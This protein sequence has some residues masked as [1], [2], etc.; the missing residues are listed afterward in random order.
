MRKPLVFDPEPMQRMVVVR[1][2]KRRRSRKINKAEQVAA[3]V[4]FVL[5]GLVVILLLVAVSGQHFAQ[6]LLE[7]LKEI[8]RPIKGVIHAPKLEIVALVI[9]ALILVYMMPGVESTVKRWLG[10]NSRT[11]PKTR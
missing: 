9:A 7:H 8:V 3:R 11:K 10:I 5:L 2:R 4:R 6:A 1:R